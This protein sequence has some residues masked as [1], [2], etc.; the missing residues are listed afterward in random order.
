MKTTALVVILTAGISIAIGPT[1]SAQTP[2]VP[3]RIVTVIPA[4]TEILFA[5]G[6]GHQV[7]GIGSFDKLPDGSND[8][9]IAR[10]GGL[11]DPDTERMLTLWPDLAVLYA[12]QIDLRRQ[13]QR[14]GIPVLTFQHGGLID[15]MEM[16]RTIGRRI[17]REHEGKSLVT[18]LE[19]GLDAVSRRVAGK[20]RPRTLLVFAR[21]PAA[22]R[23]IYA[24][25]GAG[26]LHDMLTIAGGDNVFG[27]IEG[28]R[29]SQVSSEAILTA[30]PDVVIEIRNE[31][32]FDPDSLAME[33]VVW[34]RFSTV[35]AV[36]SNRVY[37]LS[38]SEFVVPGPRVLEAVEQLAKLLH[39][40]AF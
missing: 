22:L 7:V 1:V 15:V 27:S 25:G 8:T 26:F 23:G 4:V 18:Q 19:S 34:Q 40:D 2:N 6:A 21:E 16:I 13:L 12:S 33:R 35:P 37:F 11:L 10:V 39:P 36:R 28:E 14:A 9:D 24:S 38:G 20:P 32:L 3:Q 31:G 30:A 29:V 5:L 17:G